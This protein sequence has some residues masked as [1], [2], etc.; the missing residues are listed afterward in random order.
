M[1]EELTSF[2]REKGVEAYVAEKKGDRI[3]LSDDSKTE[4]SLSEWAKT[5]PRG[6]FEPVEVYTSLL[7]EKRLLHAFCT[8][9][10]MKHLDGT[11]V[12][13]V[14]VS[15]KD[16]RLGAGEE[17][18][19]FYVT[20]MRFWK[21]KKVLQTQAMRWPIEGFHRDAKQSLVR[22][23]PSE[24]DQGRQAPHRDGLLRLRPPAA[25]L[26]LRQDHGEPESQSKND[27]LKV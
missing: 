5:I 15:Y 27:L 2:I 25:R 1:S 10:R 24:E 23:L 3:T 6:S 21:S 14:V 20:N 16:E 26:W 7:G 13:M 22:G 11:K 12:K 4:T 8:S 9:L 17:G 19:S 18:P